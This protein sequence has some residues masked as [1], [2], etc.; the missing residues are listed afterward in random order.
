MVTYPRSPLRCDG[1]LP[2]YLGLGDR[3]GA[4]TDTKATVADHVIVQDVAALLQHGTIA[5]DSFVI[6]GT[7]QVQVVGRSRTTCDAITIYFGDILLVPLRYV[8]NPIV[9]LTKEM[10][11]TIQ[12]SEAK[13]RTL[14]SLTLKVRGT[15]KVGTR[16]GHDRPTASLLTRGAT[17]AVS[18]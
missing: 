7:G 10:T 14:E 5:L 3:S 17:L 1:H 6:N 11:I 12:H 18:V 4:E 9:G 13:P 15:V 2:P 8:T 16:T